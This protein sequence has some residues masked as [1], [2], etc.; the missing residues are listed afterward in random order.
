MNDVGTAFNERVEATVRQVRDSSVKHARRT[1][2]LEQ[3]ATVAVRP[4]VQEFRRFADGRR[5]ALSRAGPG[6][7]DRHAATSSG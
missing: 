2:S 1:R 5:G 3:V 7:L 4:V 6:R